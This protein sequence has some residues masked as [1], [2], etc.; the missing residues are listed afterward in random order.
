M[1]FSAEKD[2]ALCGLACVLCS[3]EK[4]PGCKARGCSQGSDCTVYQCVT[5]KGIDG[6]YECGEPVC[7][8][9]MLQGTRIRAF[10]R[11]AREYGKAALL[12]R[13][14]INV[15]QGIVYHRPD[16]LV[17]DYDALK[18]EDEIIQ[19]LHYGQNNPYRQC[20]VF[21]TEHFT[22]R[23]LEKD[24]A[25]ALLVCYSDPKAQQFFNS[26]NCQGDFKITKLEDS[27]NCVNAWLD[28]YNNQHFVRF[29]IVDKPSGQAVGTIEMFGR[30]G[31]YQTE[32]GVLRLDIA[33]AYE[34]EP[35]LYELFAVCDQEFF[36]L[37]DVDAIVTK[38]IPE[39]K[40]R[41][42]VLKSLGFEAYDMADREH[43]W[44]KRAPNR[45]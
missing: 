15:Q 12:E 34:T 43:Y 35:L 1:E 39:A 10:N 33:S 3:E 28:A 17:G 22:L 23:M 42:A 26:D 24:D 38:A 44:G 7:D 41:I 20:P 30:I 11:Y 19:L 29:A 13:L 37:F 32:R 14:R 21:E 18:T 27:Q 4:C 40:A 2:M 36:T 31:A 16:G 45:A 5:D 25:E 8:E 6:C 9:K